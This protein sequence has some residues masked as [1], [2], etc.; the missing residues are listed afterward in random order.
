MKSPKKSLDDLKKTSLGDPIKEQD[1]KEEKGEKIQNQMDLDNCSV[2]S[3]YEMISDIFNFQELMEHPNFGVKRYKNATYKGLINPETREREGFGVLI[4][5]TGRVYEGEWIQDKR[6]G[7]GYETFKTGNVYR[8]AFMNNKPHGKGIY[9][10]ANGEVYDGEFTQGC[11]NGFGI[12]KGLQN[13][14]YMGEWRDNKVW[15]YGVHQWQNGDKYEG[16][17]ARSLKNG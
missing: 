16:E 8:G 15:G 14:S 1:M 3:E 2:K 4:N 12:W 9:N 13:D 5:N 11:K 7:Q 17:W 6:N 10:W